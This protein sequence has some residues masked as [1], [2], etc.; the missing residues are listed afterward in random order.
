MIFIMWEKD[1]EMG[2][3]VL[4]LLCSLMFAGTFALVAMIF[5]IHPKNVVYMFLGMIIV[6]VLVYINIR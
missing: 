2:E 4:S 3:I 5:N 6:F 1:I